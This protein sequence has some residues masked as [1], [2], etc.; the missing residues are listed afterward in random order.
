MY[1]R[2][3]IWITEKGKHVKLRDLTSSHLENII[4]YMNKKNK[5]KMQDTHLKTLKQ[6]LRLRKL[7]SIENN[8][9]Y[10]DLF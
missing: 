8:P 6:E 1:D 5:S 3:K 2:D 9:D 4:N 10:K 7:N